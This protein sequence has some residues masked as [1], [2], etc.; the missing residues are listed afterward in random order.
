MRM[1]WMRR[2]AAGMMALIVVC[3]LGAATS[4]VARALDSG[5]RVVV[6]CFGVD[7]ADLSRHTDTLMLAV[8]DPAENY[9]GVLNIPRDT[10]VNIPGYRF[11]RVNEIYGYHLRRSADREKAAERIRGGVETLLSS[12]PV[13]VAV[14]YHIGF[15]FSGFMHMVDL[16]G[17]VWVTVKIPM[18][19]DDNAG[20]YHFHKEPGRYLL[21]G[22]E[23]LRYVR[24]RGQTG[25]RGRIYRQQEFIR[26]LIKRLANPMMV[27]KVPRMMAVVATSLQTNLSFWDVVYLAAAV[28]RV[29]SDNTGFYILPGKPSGPFWMP[30]RAMAAEMAS[31]LIAGR[32]PVEE[33]PDIAPQSGTI[34]VNVWNASGHAGLAYKITRQLR[35]S[36][37]D[38]VD[39]GNYA[40]EQLQTRVIDRKGRIGN[41]RTVSESLGVDN[42]HSEPNKRALV[43]VEVVLGS[44][45]GGN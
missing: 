20:N 44:N 11:K 6:L 33:V 13:R 42:Y 14:P 9:M 23:A 31:H 37:F 40:A 12:G 34:T 10:R 38:V 4:P 18:H 21:K 19:Y 26:N 36:G 27:F 24:F 1:K 7:A 8:F 3:L 29:R 17:G 30:N 28:R 5:Q 2:V 15:D 25:D 35:R 22:E 16:V 43:D 45:F 41:A 39:W 32:P